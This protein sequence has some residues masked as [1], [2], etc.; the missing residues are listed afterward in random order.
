MAVGLSSV[1]Q[2]VLPLLYFL[3]ILASFFLKVELLLMTTLINVVI[4]VMKPKKNS[5]FHWDVIKLLLLIN[6][7]ELI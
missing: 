5:R 4:E 6:K 7:C 1:M 2:A 3:N